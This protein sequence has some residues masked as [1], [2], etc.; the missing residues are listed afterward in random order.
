MLI[1]ANR[2]ELEPEE[3]AEQV[4]SVIANWA[5]RKCKGYVDP[6]KLAR[7]VNNLTINKNSISSVSTV[8]KED[9]GVFPFL[10]SFRLSHQDETIKGRQ[11]ITEVGVRQ[12]EYGGVVDCTVILKTDEVSAKVIAP[13][14]VTR[15]KLVA[16]LIEKCRPINNTPG[17]FPKTLTEENADSFL[18]DVQR[19][20][21]NS[22]IVLISAKDDEF[23]TDPE[24]IRRQVLGL[25]DVVVIP[26]NTDTFKL[27]EL[28]GR[29]YIVFSG[30]VRIIF[31]SRTSA[32]GSFIETCFFKVED[33]PEK[34]RDDN[35]L[36]SEILSS[37]AHRTNIPLS[38]RHVSNET[39]RFE[40]LRARLSEAAAQA[41]RNDSSAEIKDYAE[42]LEA[43]D[44][45][46]KSKGQEIEALDQE[47]SELTSENRKAQVA[48]E[49]LQY[50][51]SGNKASDYDGDLGGAF[52]EIRDTLSDI[53]SKT[54]TLERILKLVSILY[55]DRLLVLDSA[56]SSAV[57]SDKAG[58]LYSFNAYDLLTLLV[59][60]YWQDMSE[61]KG[62]QKAKSCFGNSFSAN[63][64]KL[65]K[66][67]TSQRT[68]EYRGQKVFMSRH[69]KHGVKDSLAKTLRIHFHWDAKARLIVIGHCGKHLDL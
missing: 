41:K 16:D 29:K 53:Q 42:L 13:I 61:G 12:F 25:A 36:E 55:P 2:F 49:S 51:L 65:T 60:K 21:R 4:V 20:S 19:D 54:V 50:K 52:Y 43:A 44:G 56:F 7:G 10:F 69:L 63:E 37:I 68:F 14:K 48:I 47:I 22:A 30:A 67:G 18:K 1:Y 33:W 23:F 24:S 38:R 6:I 57:E 28:I 45:E 46:L 32:S 26:K 64:A 58:F 31:P 62:D 59:C 40:V 5:G 8:N 66:E 17:L 34:G 9:G 27:E 15:P 39:V 11:W 35:T 3:G